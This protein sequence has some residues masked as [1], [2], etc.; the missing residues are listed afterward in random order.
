MRRYQVPLKEHNFKIGAPATTYG[1]TGF[2]WMRQFKQTCPDVWE[3]IDFSTI[4][5][6]EVKFEWF[7]DFIEKWHKEFKKD[8]LITEIAAH[9]FGGSGQLDQAGVA[10][11]MKQAVAYAMKTGESEQH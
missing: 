3:A 2:E 6:Y 5:F 8:I 11:F 7:R 9:S 10:H 4:H 1:P